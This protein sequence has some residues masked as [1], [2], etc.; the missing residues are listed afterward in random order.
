MT[1][2]PRRFSSRGPTDD[3]SEFIHDL[4]HRKQLAHCEGASESEI[5]EFELLFGVRCPAEYRLFLTR[6]GALKASNGV[7]IFGIGDTG[8]TEPTLE[9]AAFRIRMEQPFP[10]DLIPIEEL[11]PGNFACLQCNGREGAVYATAAPTQKT[12][13]ELRMLAPSFQ[14]YLFDRL[15]PW[16]V[17]NRHIGEYQKQFG[18]DH[19]RGGK[20]PRNHDWRPYRFCVQDVVF[21]STVL[22]HSKEH[23]CL[24]VDVFLPAE[25][26]D[27]DPLAGALALLMFLLSEAFK[28]GG[29]MEIR[30][31]EKGGHR[32][33]PQAIRELASR[34]RLQIAG[35]NRIT[36]DE[37][38]HL[39]L[40]LT[41][42]APELQDLIRS[43]EERRKLNSVRACYVVHHGIWTCEQVEM[44]L[45][46]SALPDLILSGDVLPHARHLYQHCLLHARG[47]LLAGG[48]DRRLRNPNR[49]DAET[50]V[51]ELEDDLL[52]ITGQFEGEPFARIF[53]CRDP[54]VVPWL[55]GETRVELPANTPFRVLVRA[56]D[57]ADLRRHL[58]EDLLLA[59]QSVVQ[60][61][62]PAYVLVP[63]D[64]GALP[65]AFASHFADTAKALG[66][67]LLISPEF[68]S[69]L[70]AEAA[71]KLARSRIIRQ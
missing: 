28:C 6:F 65:S 43:L 25:I 24:E 41:G 48:L 55:Q 61:E 57:E 8:G 52:S 23:N 58:E 34:S 31:Q 50:K 30:F 35:S 29:S 15:R 63:A 7:V 45:L 12:V 60:T 67:G 38:K 20:L 37:A 9:E 51:N 22:R 21:G 62:Y 54:I 53:Q 26:P 11:T 32:G 27:Y 71:Q 36:S 42:F 2:G 47:A 64:F 33:V 5:E 44:I 10:R 56:R 4:A 66:V 39:Y 16:D 14:S 49:S 70:D 13:E 3:F 18:Y 68:V 46:G 59:R 17:L 1:K 69:N 19:H 40:A